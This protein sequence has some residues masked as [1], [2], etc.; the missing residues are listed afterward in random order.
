MSRPS[1]IY[2][3]YIDS[4][5]ERVWQ[6]LTDSAFTRQ[7]WVNHRN[8]SDWKVGSEWR[9]EDYDDASLVDITGHVVESSPPS[10]L[11]LTW[12]S[13]NDAKDPEKVSRVAFDIEPYG[14]GVRLTVTHSELEPDSAMLSGISRGWPLV[15]SSLKTLL[16]TGEPLPGTS[17][18]R[19]KETASA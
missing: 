6:A 9:H 17:T 8:A 18:R 10:H 5:P 3:T 12:A 11:V 16:E 13:A 15:L 1:F 7:Y 14:D 2:V 4:T 19:C